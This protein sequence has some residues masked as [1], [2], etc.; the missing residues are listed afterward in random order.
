[1]DLDWPRVII[2]LL[3]LAAF[4]LS[5]TGLVLIR[6]DAGRAVVRLQREQ[7]LRSQYSGELHAVT[8]RED[9]TL[10]ESDA[11]LQR[12]RQQHE[13]AGIYAATWNTVGEEPLA[14]RIILEL[15]EG[16][17]LDFW[18]VGLGLLCGLAA[19]IWGTW[20]PQP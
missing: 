20:L 12:W 3:T 1:M 8:S 6:R 15:R 17:R 11:A 10:A 14:E 16:S 19:S 5:T 9:V 2:T 13:A 18:L 7:R 4:G